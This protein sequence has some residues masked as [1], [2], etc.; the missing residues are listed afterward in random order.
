MI[1]STLQ[2]KPSEPYLNEFLIGT[3]E[4]SEKETYDQVYPVRSRL[5]YV[6]F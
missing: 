1:L 4:L 6:W 5:Q 2:F 3:K